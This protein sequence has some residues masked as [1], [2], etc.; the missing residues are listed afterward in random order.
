MNDPVSRAY[1]R[2]LA[3]RA[4]SVPPAMANKNTSIF[5]RDRGVLLLA[6]N[7]GDGCQLRLLPQI[8]NAD[9]ELAIATAPL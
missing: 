7:Q 4:L 2:G 9:I 5:P 6:K 1:T 8:G 3:C